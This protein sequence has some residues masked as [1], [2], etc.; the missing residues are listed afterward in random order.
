ML[1]ILPGRMQ[2]NRV[3]ANGPDACR[4]EFDFYYADGEAGRA[5]AD[6]AFSDSV[7]DEDRM[8]CE[9]VQKGLASGAYRPGR[10]SP[11]QEAGV[12][13]WHNLLRDAYAACG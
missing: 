8:I 5:E 6:D 11:D 10:L 7:Q 9:H 13:H 4:V 3:V 12:W 2:T 1:N